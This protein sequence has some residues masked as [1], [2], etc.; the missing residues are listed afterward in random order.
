MT[1]SVFHE[2]LNTHTLN[3]GVYGKVF[4]CSDIKYDG[5]LVAVKIVRDEPL[6]RQAALNEIKVLKK[7]NGHCGVL[8]LCRDFTHLNH[9]CISV[10][11]YGESLSQ[12]LKRVGKLSL[13]QV[14]DVGLQLFHGIN[15]M[16]NCNI[17]HT[18]L[19]TE[20]ILVYHRPD[21]STGIEN[22]D[23]KYPLSV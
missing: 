10:D 20:N 1:R 15:H 18:D 3:T 17:V 11:L 21:P 5:S 7:L 9:V 4:E 22:D 19:K 16:H 8:R 2:K 6:F 12:K 14:A 13:D 23:P